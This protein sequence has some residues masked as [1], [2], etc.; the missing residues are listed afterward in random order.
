MSLPNQLDDLWQDWTEKTLKQKLEILREA[1]QR[2]GKVI[3]S[4][5][6][7]ENLLDRAEE[8][9]EALEL[10]PHT[11]AAFSTP[12]KK[13]MAAHDPNS[14]LARAQG[15]KHARLQ[16]LDGPRGTPKLNIPKDGNWWTPRTK[17]P[18]G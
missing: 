1:K 9:G 2:A 8:V 6:D 16:T 15:R 17:K 3:F 14:Q 10:N 7:A 12:S 5:Q 11:E 4:D 13:W 18:Q